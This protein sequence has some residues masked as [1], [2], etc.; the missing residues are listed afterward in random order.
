[1]MK[2][3][4]EFQ[5]KK[6]E[7]V[8][9]PAVVD[10]IPEIFGDNYKVLSSGV[11]FSQGDVILDLGAN[12]GVFSCMMAEMFPQARIIALEPVPETFKIL[13]Q[14]TKGY[15]NIKIYNVGVGKERWPQHL[16]VARGYSGGS[17]SWCTY[18][19]KVHDL[20][21]VEIITLDDLWAIEI[22]DRVKLM[23]M[24]IEGMEYDALYGTSVLDRV[25]YFTGEF[26]MNRKLDYEC[27]RMQGLA[28]WVSNR[29]K[30]L[31]FEFCNMAE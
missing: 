9:T 7:F 17:T 29:T 30:V 1:M 15:P 27:M 14:N 3:T 11:E 8:D 18:D 28:A 10:L 5:G 22:L 23:K 31:N 21:E 26:H 13:D 4:H 24:D 19:P 16:V 12:E 20:V 25:E 2:R 6:F